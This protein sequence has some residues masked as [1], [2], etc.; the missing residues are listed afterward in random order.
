[1]NYRPSG[2]RAAD[3]AADV[4]A[5]VAAGRA[6]PGTLLPPVRALAAELGVA[7]GTVA[8]AYRLL[9]QR[10]VVEGNARAGTRILGRPGRAPDRGVLVPPGTRDLASGNPDPTLLPDIEKALAKI[11]KRQDRRM[12][13]EP[14]VDPAFAD[15]ARKR[16]AA[17]RM[18]V[19]AVTVT[20]GAMDAIERA[21][22]T[23]LRPGMRVAV[24]DPGYAGLFDLLE[25]M[26]L[27]AEPVRLDPSGMQPADLGAALERGAQAVVVTPRAQ[28][29]T[30]A[31][32]D[33]HRVRGL[34]NVLRDYP[35]V[36]VIEDD[37][38]GDVAGAPAI[39]LRN[40]RG[41]VVRSTSKSLGPDLRV[42][43][44]GG[45]AATIGAIESRAA[46]GAGWV[47]HILQDLVRELA[48]VRGAAESYTARRTALVHELS[49]RNVPAYG[50]SGFNVW[51]P[52]AEEAPVVAAMAVRG[53]A[54][55]G[56]ARFRIASGPAVRLTISAL[57]QT[58]VVQ[59]AEDLAAS[60]QTRGHM[61]AG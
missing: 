8:A 32:L 50:R 36:L 48:P 25:A 16:F 61:R 54:V 31:A 56:G 43:I 23:H 7:A 37:H 11:A 15:E 3:I 21:L 55:A 40:P 17:D 51:V 6:T 58:E 1:M 44:V 19:E 20:G 42:A 30:G 39:S 38:A 57:K 59:V 12:Y 9:S 53:W 26:G 2:Q 41:I 18:P 35:Q 45:D 22:A 60:V 13:G 4:E 47:S 52:V 28:N 14:R 33:P 29:P 49:A 5:A 24:E 27:V 34:K 46:V 10:G